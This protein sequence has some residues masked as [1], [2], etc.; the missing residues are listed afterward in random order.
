MSDASDLRPSGG[1]SPER[2]A[3]A[4]ALLQKRLQR[5]AAGATPSDAIPR[6]G[7]VGPTPVSYAQERLWFLDR[8]EPGSAAYNIPAVVRWRGGLRVPVLAAALNEIV[9]R[10]EALRTTFAAADGGEGRVV[11]RVAS[12]LVLPL[13]WI[14]LTVLG[15]ADR[16]AERERL[17]AF[18]ARRPFDL[19]RGPLLRACLLRLEGAGEGE[20]EEH[21]LLATLHHIVSDGWS[22]GLLCEELTALYGAFAAGRPSPLPALSIQYPDFAAWQR[23]WLRGEVLAGQLAYWRRQLAGAPAVLPLPTD[24]PRPALQGFAG[25]RQRMRLS[26]S[27][28]MAVAALSR[29][30]GASPFMTLLA[31]FQAL[32]CRLTGEEDLPVGTPVAGRGRVETERLIGLFVNTLVLRT[33]ASGDPPFRALLGRVRE[34]ALAAFAHQDVPFEKLVLELRPER[35]LAHTPLFQVMMILQNAPTGA[36]ARDELNLVQMPVESGTAKFDLTLSLAEERGLSAQLEYRT[37]LFDR[38]TARRLLGHFAV[39]LQAAVSEPGQQLSSLPLLTAPERQQL[40]EWSD[41]G[42]AWPDAETCLHR[43]FE[44]QAARLPDGVALVFEGARLTYRELDGRAD[45]LARSLCGMGVGPEIRVGVA[46]ARSFDL[47]VALLGVLKAGGAYVPLD[48]EYPEE[49]LRF[50][51]EDSGVTVLLTEERLL[52]R[53]PPDSEERGVRA[54]CLDGGPAVAGQ[55]EGRPETGASS[56]HAAYAIFTSGSTGRPK[57]AVNTHRAIVNRLLWMQEAYGLTA[58]DGVL[59]KTPFSFDVSVWEFFWPLITGTRL[60]IARPGGHQDPAYLAATIAEQGITTLHFVPSMLQLFLEED[61]AGCTGLRRVFASGEA[62]PPELARRFFARLTAPFGVELHNLYGPT[63]AAVDVTFHP[64]RPGEERLPIG[65]PVANTR[66]HLLDRHGGPVAMGVPGEL[67]IGG[68]QVGRGYLRR[69]ELTAERFVPDPFGERGA[70]LYRTGDLARRLADGEVEYLGRGDHQVK[71]RGCRIELGEIDAALSAHPGVRDA[72]TLARRDS[73]GDQ[74]LVAYVVAAAPQVPATWTA[75]LRAALKAK[76]PDFMVPA[77]FVPLPAL[78]LLPNGKLDRVALPRPEA[79]GAAA[80]SAPIALPRTEAERAIAGIWREVLGRPE[81]GIDDN[82]F[83][84]GGHSLLLVRVQ[85]RLRELLDRDLPLV[86]LFRHPTV[87]A[88]AGHLSADREAPAAP[89]PIATAVPEIAVVG[90]AG[91]F[92]QA[93]S[94]AEL[95]RKL[96]AGDELITFFSAEEGLAAGLPPEVVRDPRY[97]QARGVLAGPELFDAA[98]FDLSPREAQVMDPQQRILLETAWQALEDAGYDAATWPGRIGVFAGASENVHVQNVYASRELM[99]AVGPYQVSVGNRNDYLASRIS[100]KLDLKGPSVNVQTAC[101]TSLVAVH[102]ACRSLLADEC[103]LVLAGGVSVTSI[104]GVGYLY[105]AGGIASPDGHCRA[106]DAGARGTVAGNGAALV[107]LKR[108]ADA[109]A[110]G[111]RIDAVLRGSAINNDGALKVGF[112]APSVDGQAAVIAAAQAAAGVDPGSIGYVEAHGTGTA[113]G[114]PIEI[115]ALTQAFRASTGERGFCAIGSVKTNLGHLD[116]AAGV[117]GL[118]KAVLA[119]KHGLIPPSLHY[120]QPNPAIDFASSPFRVNTRLAAWRSD[121][122][123]RRAGVSS[124]GIGGTNAHAILEQAPALPEAEATPP[125]RPWHLLLLS[126]K[127]ATALD[128]ATANLA[129][130]LAA[131]GDTMEM[132]DVAYTLQVGRRGLEHRRMLVCGDRADAATALST[133][134]PE[135]VFT[136]TYKGGTRPVVFL[137]PGQGAQSVGMGADLH[138][139]EPAF[140]DAF[141]RCAEL[142]RPELGCDLKELLSAPADGSDRAAS[143]LARTALAQPALFAVEYA[144]ARLWM[145]WGVRPQAMLGHSLGEYVAA[146]LAGVFSLADGLRLVAARGRLMQGLPEGAM[147]GVALPE[148]KL[149]PLLGDG[150]EIAA[151]NAPADCVA[152]GPAGAVEEFHARLAE[153]G[154]DCRRLPT[155]HAF[156]SRMMEPAVAPFRE[157]VAGVSLHKPRIPYLS[158]VTGTWITAGEATDPGYWA[159]H[160]RQTV[161]F[162]EGLG[163]LL[164]EPDRVLLEVGPGRTLS[165]LAGRHPG[166][167]PGQAVVPSLQ[168]RRDS[169]PEVPLLLAAAGKL[170]LAGVKLDAEAMHAG[171]RHRRVPLPTYPFERQRYWIA[172]RPTAAASADRR[173][174]EPLAA[175]T[176]I[177]EAPTPAPRPDLSARYAEPLDATEREIAELWRETLGVERV[178][179]GDDFFELGGHSLM[180]TRLVSRLRDRF[181]I[182]VPIDAFFAAPTIAGLARCVAAAG[183]AAVR[184]IPPAPRDRDLPLSFAQQR[185]WF[186]TQLEPA[187]P[188]YNMPVAVRFQGPLAPPV[189]ARAA[190][191]ILRRHESLRTTFARAGAEPVQVVSPPGP[192]TL[193]VIGL[194]EIP[195]AGAEVQR[196]V[197]AEAG[198]PF[199]LERGPLWR[200]RALRLAADDHVVTMTMHHIVSDGWSIG[201]LLHEL[202]VLYAAFAR[203][204]ESPLPPLPVQYPDFAVWQRAWLSGDV[205]AAQIG[206]WRERLSGPLPVL[207]LPL[208]RPRPPLQTFRGARLPLAIPAGL[209]ERLRALSQGRGAT[210]FMLLLAAFKTLLR[211]YTSQEDLLV[212]APIAGRNRS[213]LEG[214]I[215]FFVNTLVLRTDLSGNPCFAELLDRVRETTVGAYAHQD[216]PFEKLVEEVRPGRDLARS[217]LFQVM[218]GLENSP[219][220]T[221]AAPAASGLALTPLATES[222]ASRFEWTLFL[223][224]VGGGIGRIGGSLEY[225]TDLFD[226]TTVRRMVG[227]FANLLAAAADAPAEPISRLRLL[228]AGEASQL[229]VE[230]TETARDFALDRPVHA[231]VAAQA[232]R[233]PDAP[234][235]TSAGETLSY[236]ELDLRANRLAHRLRRLGVGP[237]VPVGIYLERSLALPV[238]LLAV[239]KAGGAYVPLDPAYPPERLSYMLEDSAAPVVLTQGSLLKGVPASSAL[240]VCLDQEDLGGESAE[241]P[242]VPASPESLAYVLYTSGSTGRPKGVQIAHGALVNFLESMRERP[243]LAAADRLLAVTSVS[244]DIAGLELYLPLVAGARVEIAGR[245]LAADGPQLLSRLREATVLQATPSAWRLLLDAGWT[246][247]ADGMGLKA[248]CGGEALPPKLAGEVAA[249]AGSLWNLYGPTETTVWSATRRVGPEVGEGRGPVAIG[250]PIANTQIYVVDPDLRPVPLGVRGELLIGGTGLA[251]GYFGRPDLTAERFVPD[252]FA[253][254]PGAAGARLYRTGDLARWR[255]GGELEFLGRLDRQVKLRGFRIEL[256]EVEAALG[257]HPAVRAAVALVREDVQGDQRLTAYVV[258]DGPVPAGGELRRHLRAKLPESMVPSAFVVLPELPLLPNGKVDR[259][260]L[261]APEG[262]RPD[263]AAPFTVA[264]GRLEGALAAVWRSVLGV[265]RVGVD[266][267]FFDLGGHSLLLAEVHHKLRESLP[268]DLGSRLTMVELFQYPTIAALARHLRP[269]IAARISSDPGRLR[270]EVRLGSLVRSPSEGTEIA[271]VGMSGR[272]PGAA[273]V[274]Q[275]WRNLRQGVESISRFSAEELTA[276]GID[277]ALFR[278]PGYI[279]AKG[280]PDGV[281]WFDAGFFGYTPREAEIID[282]QQR[283]FLEIAW[284]ALEDA[285]CDP[286]RHPGLIGVF[287]GA[288]LNT[289]LVNLYSNPELMAAVGGFQAMISNDK[290]FLPTRVSYKLNLQGP[291][292]NVQTACSTSLVAVHLACQHL[293]HGECDLALAGGV[294]LYSPVKAGAVYQEGGILAP[295]GHCRAFDERA[296]GTVVGNGAAV[297]VLKRL[298]DALADGD[299]IYAVI[300]GSAINNDGS[301]KVGYTAPSVEG[302]AAVISQA[303]AMAGVE[304]ETIRYVET[305][306]TGTALGD[307]IEVRALTAAF[308]AGTDRNGFCGI[309]AIKSNL[310]HLDTAAGVAGLIKAALALERGELPPSLHFER[311]NPALDLPNTPFYVVDRLTPWPR[312]GPPRRAGV[313]AFGIGGTNAHVILEEAPVPAGTAASGPSRTAQLLVLSARTETALETATDNLA[314]YLVEHREVALADVA[315]TLHTGRKVFRHRRTVVAAGV[316]EAAALLATR[317]PKRVLSCLAEA[318]DRPVV[319][320]FAGGGAQYPNM[321]LDLYRTEPVFCEQVDLCLRLFAPHVD[322]DL[323]RHLFPAPGEVEEATRSLERTSIALPVLFAVEYAQAKLWMSW[324]VHPQAMIGHSLGEYVAACLAG[325]ISLADAAALVALRGQLFETLPAGGML[326]VPLAEGEV[327]PLLRELLPNAESQLSIAAVNSPAFCVV[328][329]PAAAIAR[330]REALAGRGIEARRLHI[331]VAA[332]SAE[333]EPIL[334]EFGDFVATLALSPPRIPYISNVTGTWMTPADAADPGYWMRH[335]RQTVRFADGVAELLAE[336]ERIFLEVGPGQTLCTLVMQHPARPAGQTVLHSLRHPQDRQSDVGFLLQVLGKLW[337]AGTAVDWAGFYAGERRRRLRLP[338]YPFERQLYWIEPRRQSFEDLGR[339]V[340]AA[341]QPDVADWFWVPAWRQ[342][343]WPRREAN[344]ADT[345]D[346]AVPAAASWLLFV[347]RQGLGG[348]LAERLR[349]AGHRVAAV[350]PGDAFTRLGEDA[351]TVRPRERGDYAALL[352]DLAADGRSPDAI[353]HLWCVGAA[354]EGMALA[355]LGFYSLLALAQALGERPAPQPVRIE[356]LS[357]GVQSVTGDE[358]IEP[359]KALVL[360]LVKVVPQE[361]PHLAW[362][363]IDV[364]LPVERERARVHRLAAELTAALAA[365]PPPAEGVIAYRGAHRWVQGFEAVRLPRPGG[366][367]GLRPGG[368]YLITGGLGGLGLALAEHLARTAK[369]RLVLTGRSPFPA[370]QDWDGWLGRQGEDDR[371]SRKI[372]RLQALEES[373]AEVL[374]ARADAG[375]SA[376]MRAVLAAA[377]ERFGRPLSGVIHAAGLP[378]GG[379][380]QLKTPEAVA[381][382]L[383][384]K[385]QGTLSLAA[386]LADESLDF[387]VL[388][389]AVNSVLGGFGRA[390]FCAA[391]AFLDAF[392]QERAAQREGQTVAL[393]WDTWSETGVVAESELPPD[394]AAVR[395]ESLRHGMSTREGLEVFDRVLASG[396]PRVVVSTRPLP[397]LLERDLP[398]VAAE[399]AAETAAR[400]PRLAA[401]HGRPSLSTAYVAP[402]SE[403]ERTIAGIWEEFLGIEGLGVHDNFF[404]LGGHSLMATQIT[405]RFRHTFEA[406]LSI[407][408]FFDAPTIA[409]LAAALSRPAERTGEPAS[410]PIPALPRDGRAFPLSFAQQRLWFLDQLEPGSSWYNMPIPL[411]LRGRLDAAALAAALAEVERRHEALRTTFTL[412]GEG[413]EEETAVQVVGPPSGLPLPQIDLR[414][415]PPA[416][417]EAELLR[418]ARAEAGRPFALA[419]GPLERA[420]LFALGEGEQALLLNQHHIVCDGWS[421][422]VLVHEMGT[423]YEA[424]AHGRPSPLP[425]LPI[426]YADFAVWQRR[427]LSGPELDRLLAYWQRQLA[428]M[429]PLLELPTDRPRPSVQTFRGATLPVALPPG[430][431]AAVQAFSRRAGATPFMTLLAAFLALLH[432][433]TR[434]DD[435]VVGSPIANR[436]RAEIEG[437]IGFFVNTLVLRTDLAGDP[438]FRELLARVQAMAADVYAHQ[439]LPFEKLVEELAPGRQLSHNP[440]FQVMF[441]LQNAPMPELGISG[442]TLGPLPIGNSISKFDLSLYFWEGGPEL[443]SSL[444]YNTDLF[445]ASTIARLAAHVVSLIAG[446]LAGPERRLSALPLLSPAERWQLL[447]EWNDTFADSPGACLHLLFTAQAARTPDALAVTD[448]QGREGLT[449]AE[450]A[451]RADRLARHLRTLGVGPDVPVAV[452]LRRSPAMTLAVLAALAAGGAYVPVDPSYPRERLERML[453]IARPRVLL[454]ETGLREAIP[455]GDFAVLCL[456]DGDARAGARVEI[457]APALAEVVRPDHLA[458]VIFT[459]GSTGVPKGVAMPHRS[460]ANLMA[461][462][463]CLSALGPG[464]RTL[465]FASLSFDVSCQELFSTWAAGGTLVLISE[466][467]RLDAAALLAALCDQGIERLFLPFVALQQLAEVAIERGVWPR[468]LREVVTAGEQLQITKAVAELFNRVPECALFNQYGPAETHVVTAHAL[469]GPARRWPALPPIGVPVTNARILLL[470]RAF[471]LVPAGVPGELWIGG[472]GLARGYLSRPDLTAERFVP[473]PYGEAGERLYRTGDLARWRA[474]GN[475]EFLGRIDQQLKIRGFRVEPGEVEVVL[476]AHPEVRECVVLAR[477]PLQNGQAGARLLAYVVAAQTGRLS[478][479]ALRDHLKGSLPEYMVPSAFVLLPALPLTPSGKVDRQALP[480]PEAEPGGEEETAAPLA[481]TA[482]ILVGIWREVLGRERVGVRDDFFALGGHSLLATQVVSRVRAV[483]QVELPVRRLFE[484]PTVEALARGVEEAL[485]GEARLSVPPILP[486]APESRQG[487]LPLSFSQERLWFLDQL[488]PASAVYNLPTAFR[489]DGDLDLAAFR[490][491]LGEI[492]RR[493]AILRTTFARV[494]DRPV[495]RIA[496][497]AAVPVPRVDLLAL[498]AEAGEREARRLGREE[499]TRPFDLARGPLLRAVLLRL[500]PRRHAALFT[501][502]H[503]VADGWS[504]GVLTSELQALYTAFLHGRPSPLAEPPLQYADFAVWQRTELAGEVFERQRAYWRQRL[505]SAPGTTTFPADRARPAV[506]RFRGGQLSMAWS[507]EQTAAL[508]AAGRRCGATEFMVLLAGLLALLLRTTGQEDLVVGS[509]IAGRTRRELEPLIGFFLNT[510]A[511]RAEITGRLPFAVL[512][513]RLRERTLE[514][515][516]HQDLPFEKIVEDLAPE[517]SLAHAPLFQVLLVLQN[518]PAEALTLPDLELRRMETAS[519]TAKFDLSLNLNAAGGRLAGAWIYNRDLFDVSTIERLLGQLRTLAAAAFAA[520]ERPLAELPLLSP[521]EE[522]QLRDWNATGTRYGQAERSLPA[523]LAEQAG[524]TPEATAVRFADEVLTYRELDRR[525]H[526]LAARLRDLGVGPEMCVGIAAERSLELMIGLLAILQAGGAYLPL[527]PTH[528]AER[529]AYM[530]ADAQARVLLVQPHLASSFLVEDVQVVPLERQAVLDLPCLASVQPDH[531]AYVLY[532]SGS[533]GRPKGVMNTHRGIVNRLLWMQAQYGLGADDRVLQ[534]TPVSFDVSVWELFW[535]LLTGAQLVVARPGG[536]QDPAYLSEEI[537]RREVTTL[538]FV[539]SMLRAFLE[540]PGIERCTALARVFASGEALPAELERRHVSRLAAPL[541]NL[542]GPTEA[543]VDVTHWTCEPEGLRSSVPIGRP[544]A[545][546][547]LHLLDREGWPVPVGSPGELFIGGVQVARGYR[548][549]PALTAERFVPDPWGGEAG[550]RLYRSGDLARWLPDGAVDFLGRTDHQVKVRGFRI[551]LGEIES[552]LLACPGVR[553]AVLVARQEGGALGMRLTAYVASPD[554][555]VTAAGLREALARQLPEYMVPAAFVVLPALPLLPNGKVDRGALAR[556]PIA[557]EERRGAGGAEPKTACERELAA[558]FAHTLG[559]DRFGLHDSFFELG[560]NSI[561]GAILIARLQERLGEIVHVV[562]LF[563][564]PTVAGLAAHLTREHGAAVARLWGGGLPAL[565]EAARARIDAARLTVFRDLMAASVR[566][567]PEEEAR[568]PRAVFVLAPPRSGSTLLRVLLGGH[569]QLFAPPELELLN[570]PTLAARRAAFSGRDGFRLEGAI[571]GV[572]EAFRCSAQE[573]R[574]LVEGREAEGWSTLRFYGWMQGAIGGRTLVDKTPSYSW[575]PAALERAE[576]G[577]E[578]PLYLHLV[579]HPLGAIHS[580]EEAKLDQIF[581]PR[582]TAFSR[583]ELAELSWVVGHLNILEFLERLPARRRYTLHFEA[584]LRRPQE[585]LTDLCDF[586][587]VGFD[588]EMLDPYGRPEGRMTDGLHAASRMLGDVKFHTHSGLAPEVAER[589]QESRSEAELSDVAR[590]LHAD[591]G[592]RSGSVRVALDAPS[593]HPGCLVGLQRGGAQRPLFLV[594]PVFG[595]V[596]FYRHLAGALGPERPVYGFQAVGLDGIGEPLSCIEEMAAT[597]CQALRMVQAAG[598]YRLAGSSMGGVIAYEM[599]QQ[600]RADGDEVALLGLVDAWLLD[601]SIPEVGSEEAELAILAY[602]TGASDAGEALRQL[603]REERLAAI[604]DRGQAVGGLPASFGR[605]ELLRLCEVF[606]KNGQALRTYRPQSYAGSLVYFRAAASRSTERPEAAWSDLCGGRVEVQ[607]VPGDHLSALF[608]PHVS[609][610]GARLREVL[611]RA[612]GLHLRV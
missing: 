583:R 486:L 478:A 3:A 362:R 60:V 364:D 394:L 313:S 156:H 415:L 224:E 264:K 289:Y 133:L 326:A 318:A 268:D 251:R 474:D 321:G 491:S 484:T 14:D 265:E 66:I 54:L 137:F 20:E 542:Y 357:T 188:W 317:D 37:A 89:R 363:S 473:D 283:M 435:L 131:A 91:R 65:R 412:A 567:A 143:E 586:L 233:T 117:T 107:V 132:A 102:M 378:S 96:C 160:L 281:G 427:L 312:H 219:T 9:R 562:S 225:N 12:R 56:D 494:G 296:Q 440:L 214:L 13:P 40:L 259:K 517:R 184:P 257:Q 244:F 18:E 24:R 590:Q 33:D 596:H 301:L 209:A 211:R 409:G 112:T 485:A 21:V 83:D 119:V 161:R 113:L 331:A 256:G 386:A 121:G 29:Q 157:I 347:D 55:P 527:D 74:R 76:L 468:A 432:R 151:V 456:D 459:S 182:E 538:H 420:L 1:R 532:T 118:I 397:V 604:L 481:P 548:G 159:Q 388:C 504:M 85:R 572:M 340:A 330:A 598:P 180:A 92:P 393:G 518:A 366:S 130:H 579:R 505:A 17:A 465:Q 68:V 545:N 86:E 490:G 28:A 228:S 483:F 499:A 581:F 79:G 405:S 190:A 445:D 239:W 529:L 179:A 603:P 569:P 23:D 497:A 521:A 77:A 594:H 384:P 451:H 539:P 276:S 592:R 336:E 258:A 568:N 376:A 303:L 566:T 278:A 115:A 327:L 543:A 294:T 471:G 293:L 31:A 220:P 167:A 463:L 213:E 411:R 129:G 47:V 61:L 577:F 356:V 601:D 554:G 493:H 528:P 183:G 385:V 305:H 231:R 447:G 587:G 88:L 371:T 138:A 314:R 555:E 46:L 194:E 215:G 311:P 280:I 419:R 395:R 406:E 237:E 360:G 42:A 222:G 25:E 578:A 36:V 158:N 358:R 234:A 4:Q 507:A 575:S 552:A 11:Q 302:Q 185:L 416:V 38:T 109:V 533:T 82:F 333:V 423:L 227:H 146:C 203:G 207:E 126:A 165:A 57:A 346:A 310:G 252:P 375:D 63:E 383:A 95:W 559:H 609:V 210:L 142:L 477:P 49:R 300:K 599:A 390:D 329:G 298:A 498:P 145:A 391:S 144:L 52:A 235:V 75:E 147:L 611:A 154:V 472:D 71:V 380:I 359:E 193:P 582:A 425:P 199:D 467:L 531:L 110:D 297:V 5:K 51:L 550:A 334:R 198:R 8:L 287:A 525:A 460:L 267:N 501:V 123:P 108:L 242:G 62:L 488:N 116:A 277:P 43:L 496:P 105:E 274:E 250:R 464:A 437:L 279:N 205:L 429:P 338:S 19:E 178:G 457:A 368:V 564:H 392:A 53:L 605:R 48:P 141:D 99:E 482:E 149:R 544:V 69:P 284:E 323:R 489:L 335:L 503:M 428:G 508:R 348:R 64:C 361:M 585:V 221:V 400:S 591:L 453:A 306:G 181:G 516:T 174:R 319:F 197:A 522:Q 365:P 455:A 111:D 148:E 574:E 155:S 87:G 466:E 269:E 246:G 286:E 32:L 519:L 201:V 513:A 248:L 140:R 45:R 104:H 339:R 399:T 175:P 307:P 556:L 337:L 195:A 238:A 218:L 476:A 354:A 50:M 341:K 332:H 523:L 176:A 187:S 541:Y 249:R 7:Q 448:G 229:L 570:F 288:G 515:Y 78:P 535:P 189:L 139:S 97:V 602:L 152:A 461:W 255:A 479:G 512:L 163:E 98:F 80:Q 421:L 560:G 125:P 275:L 81:V 441:L 439:D 408:R 549:Q 612:E 382:V 315:F 597:Y 458:Y 101:S 172:P 342:A 127:T 322:A 608:P 344:A 44:A 106:F 93:E 343:S 349:E 452:C 324:G 355:D 377:H 351:W 191:E 212:G 403:D 240:P 232:A 67:H 593:G 350:T 446:A 271:I 530:L 352:R 320:L 164:R 443:V 370:R 290:D 73:P 511:L 540:S 402:E 424:F 414:G 2:S 389:S 254:A 418:L 217:P 124:F 589:W 500:A 200:L 245:A 241:E 600:L 202:T 561:A 430:T 557:P 536:H 230:W 417:G 94:V 480:A 170:W 404:E 236:G 379:M 261:P 208:D 30:E 547:R 401:S 135:R 606:V 514:A 502:H 431:T 584:L 571:R 454:T 59:Q 266:D 34:V 70:R 204:E 173:E 558:L 469:V 122:A 316:E 27:L 206:Y 422:G 295:D 223:T 270:A 216:L 226:A 162:T 247:R 444:E 450:L 487:D 475:L 128:T 39:L 16:T 150:L 100:Y 509:P 243:G 177:A 114:D 470:D 136:R 588:P 134:A 426:Q 433:T 369:A 546:T 22:Q 308:R 510:L 192:F 398:A 551:E 434:Q 396:L 58:A 291:S 304:P 553:E 103:D 595:D 381:A 495:Q 436:G 272:F 534:K 273:D 15:A 607:M 565:L 410:A 520:P 262:E 524:R 449:Y 10:H 309:G 285:A 407:A 526:A 372:R 374:I 196:L 563:D 462:Q 537:A 387:L 610:L 373:G 353:P 171:R 573:A 35:N 282:P 26:P 263:L 6:R 168:H 166:R 442:L 153:R 292:L 41:T 345:A 169:Q 253:A 299:S 438:P 186:L 328:S 576:A 84:L 72:V 90:M 580:F 413:T 120:R 506:Q 492:V 325:V 260:A 367:G